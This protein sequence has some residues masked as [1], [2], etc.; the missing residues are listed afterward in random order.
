VPY[1]SGLT[2]AAS[3]ATCSDLTRQAGRRPVLMVPPMVSARSLCPLMSGDGR[4]NGDSALVAALA[5]G[6]TCAE[7]G[8]VAGV[9]E[10]TV[11]RR[12]QE[13]DF[14]AELAMARASLLDRAIGRASDAATEAV[15]VLTSVMRSGKSDTARISAARTLLQFSSHRHNDPI[16]DAL[17]GVG[18]IT[19]TE[20]ERILSR[21]MD[22]AFDRIPDERQFDFVQA[23]Q[24]IGMSR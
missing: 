4:H 3:L 7:A 18:A 2:T 20:F 8:R 1:R 21:V 16:S 12:L 22:L 24:R 10:R 17:V 15:D 14:R 5:A 13:E 11:R 19:S 23:V 6:L 9:S